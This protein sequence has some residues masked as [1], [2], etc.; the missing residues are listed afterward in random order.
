MSRFAMETIRNIAL[1]GHPGAGKTTLF[2]AL[3]AAAGAI[4]SQGT[5]ERGNTV[6]DHDPMEKERGH[7]LNT[8]LCSFDHNDTHFNLIDTPGYPDF[9]GPT[10]AAM[11]AVE[12]VA[13]VINAQN[14]IEHGAI[15]LMARAGKRSNERMIVVNKID[16]EGVDIASLLAEIQDTFGR[17]CLPINLPADGNSKVV[18]CFFHA[19]GESDLG[20]VADFHQQIIDQVVEVNPEIMEKYLEDGEAKLTPQE[21]HDAFEQC[22]REGHL[23][24]VCFCSARS[25]VGVE[26]L[27]QFS[28]SL[29]PNPA[30]GNPPEFLIGEG[31]EAVPATVEAAPDKH[32]IAHVHKIINDPF[33]G[34]LSLFRVYQGTVKRDSQLLI[35]DGR[36]PFKVGHLFKIF[37]KDHAEVEEAIA[38]DICAVAKVEEIHFD[39]VLHDS[40]DEDHY[41][42]KPIAMPASMFGL[43]IE[44]ATRGQEQKLSGALHKL[45]EED[46]CFHVEHH[47]ELNETVVRGL[48]DLH[49]RV[50][51]AR[52]SE[53]FGVEVSTSPPRIAYRETINGSAEG[54]HRHKKQTGGAGQF[55]EVFLRVKPLERGEGF[56]FVN[57]VV[58]GAI[59]HNLIPAVEKGIH[60]VLSG[61][62][63]A[64]YAL[65]DIEVTVYDGKYHPVDSKEVA[66]AMAGKKAFL[67]GIAKA[68]PVILEPIVTLDVIVPED[69]V[70]DITA[71]LAGKRARINGT[72]SLKGGEIVVKAQVPLSEIGEFQT[73]LKAI[74]QGQGRY[75][76]EPSH[77]EAVP[78]QV[79]KQLVEAW[80]PK[81]EED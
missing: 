8:C 77:Y 54:H 57:Q 15:R 21:L 76:I 18:D 60:Q 30:E 10:L 71:S 78:A 26:E 53:R 81:A 55:G 33:V 1:T 72:D 61:G 50:M 28:I 20:P 40:H 32:V 2:E 80:K 64:G 46:P 67:D 79:Q 73:E 14:G 25:G 62:A 49:L 70:G 38:G 36:K 51:L 31:D 3:L 65:Q 35:G 58:G 44:P 69:H 24:P 39:A 5:V 41:H 37:G 19:K 56:R 66:F 6:S 7:S 9:R 47:A 22:L 52:L 45:S 68:K 63:I 4:Q 75:S 48:G 42:L 29:L 12:T 27:L 74:S 11:A 17:Q 59:P 34:K 23:V 43:A 16:A 13:V